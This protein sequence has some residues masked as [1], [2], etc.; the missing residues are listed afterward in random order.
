MRPAYLSP[1][2]RRG[3]GLSPASAA[4]PARLA[5]STLA[6]GDGRGK[7][8]VVTTRRICTSDGCTVARPSSGRRRASAGLLEE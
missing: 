4:S 6:P 2:A 5:R 8:K 7:F 1:P 3:L